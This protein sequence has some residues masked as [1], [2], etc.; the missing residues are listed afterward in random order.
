MVKLQTSGVYAPMKLLAQSGIEVYFRDSA[1]GLA[2]SYRD[3][4]IS[5]P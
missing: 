3:V 4:R 2:D 5:L 1:H